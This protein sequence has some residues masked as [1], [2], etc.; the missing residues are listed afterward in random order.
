VQ[1]KIIKSIK[2]FERKEVQFARGRR[3][4]AGRFKDARRMN[5]VPIVEVAP[6]GCSY[7]PKGVEK[8][9]GT[10]LFTLHSIAT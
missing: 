2:S 5:R 8:R 9:R 3:S 7:A 6:R 10:L 1:K 4:V